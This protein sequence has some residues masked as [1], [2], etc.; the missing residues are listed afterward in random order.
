M[1]RATLFALLAAPAAA[2]DDRPGTAAVRELLG[3]PVLTPRTTLTELQDYLEGRIPKPPKPPATATEWAA[4]ADR[5][6]AD[7]LEKVVF[8]GEAARWRTAKVKVEEAGTVPGD[9]YALKK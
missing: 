3:T 8:R 5:L 4:Q 1:Y 2:A 6:R 7:V 9:G